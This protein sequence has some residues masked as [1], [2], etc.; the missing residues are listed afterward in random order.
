MVNY[1]PFI[2]A[3]IAFT[4]FLVLGIITWSYRDV[5]NRHS[6]KTG[7]GPGHDAGH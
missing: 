5:A 2:V 1:L 6:D 7:V 4:V 3:G